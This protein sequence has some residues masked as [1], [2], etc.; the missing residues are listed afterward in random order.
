MATGAITVTAGKAW[1]EINGEVID[2]AKLNQTANPVC[3]VDENAISR[4]ELV[5]SFLTQVDGATSSIV[6]L[7]SQMVTINGYAESRY[8][9]Q[10][11]A[12]NKI[13]GMTLFVADG[14]D[15]DVSY[16]RFQADRF[17]IDDTATGGLIPFEIDGGK[18]NLTGDVKIDGALVV[19]GTIAANALN[20]ATLSAIS[21]DLGTVTAGSITSVSITGTST[22]DVGSGVNRLYVNGMSAYYGDGSGSKLVFTSGTAFDIE[23]ASGNSE[24]TLTI[25]EGSGAGGELYLRD[26]S[27]NNRAILF[28]K[29]FGSGLALYDGS[30]TLAVKLDDDDGLVFYSDTNLFRESANVLKT[31]DQF[32]AFSLRTTG[33]TILCTND[34]GEEVLLGTSGGYGYIEVGGDNGGFVDIKGP[35]SDDFDMRIICAG[36]CR[37]ITAG[38]Q[39]LLLSPGGVVRFGAHTRIGAETVT[40]YITIKDSGGTTRKL[41]VVS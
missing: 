10:V 20:V 30:D 14:P 16:V 35:N 40:G 21:A 13:A 2:L 18:I 25:T 24:V 37:I 28:G 3:R 29:E 22:L 9:L 11:A 31:D 33:G 34:D 1:D 7:Q 26:E 5:T 6:T 19:N 38:S 27:G 36:S 8:T 39:D 12:N 32:K 41:A 15:T 23:N 4:R 17:E